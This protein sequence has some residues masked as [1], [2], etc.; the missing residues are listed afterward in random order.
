MKSDIFLMQKEPTHILIVDDEPS[1]RN[2]LADYFQSLNYR[3]ST[4]E[5][6]EPALEMINNDSKIDL[7]ITDIDLP[8]MSG[9]DLL[10]M[11]REL[12]P[13][14]PVVIITG[15]KTLEYAISA[16][17]NGAHDYITKPFD[18]A[19]VRK[20]VEKVLRYRLSSQKREKLFSFTGSMNI[21]FEIPTSQIDAGVVSEYLAKFLLN[22]GFCPQDDFHQLYVA[23]MET[24]INAIEHG[25]LELPSSIKGNDFNKLMR[26]EELR[27]KR[28]NDPRYGERKIKVSFL[29]H[30]RR[31]SLTISDEGP[32]FDW[33]DYLNPQ[34]QI[35]QASTKPYGRGFM[36]IR[37]VVDEVYFN[38]QGNAITLVKT[39]H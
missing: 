30:P 15:L 7:L 31:F 25:N 13:D 12:K 8:G 22:S 14:I 29:Y 32:G 35:S 23:L 10:R 38:E 20:V 26:F 3:I 34:H 2:L 24:L 5:Q 27:E 28:L 39:K 9:I 36:L 17:K 21:N 6:A 33:K 37:H 1:I 16:I 19:D 18:P 4:A 11:T